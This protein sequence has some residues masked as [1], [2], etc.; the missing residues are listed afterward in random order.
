MSR[1]VG[2]CKESRLDRVMFREGTGTTDLKV[3]GTETVS[4][5]GLRSPA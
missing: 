2:R 4:L 3:T 1:V 5:K